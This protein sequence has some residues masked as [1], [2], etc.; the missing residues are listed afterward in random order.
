KDLLTGS[1]VL[2]DTDAAGDRADGGA[3]EPRLS[4]D[5]RYVAFVSGAS[6]LVPGANGGVFV[7]D[8]QTGAITCASTSDAGVEGGGFSEA[9]V[10][11]ADGRYVAFQSDSGNL[12]PGDTNG[13]TDVFVKDLQTGAIT[14]IVP[15]P[16][17][18]AEG[19]GLPA[20]TADGQSVA[21]ASSAT[22]LIPGD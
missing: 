19:S 18:Q 11:S 22:H 2:A 8:L 6:N 1:I 13:T 21:F 9:P 10:L 17:S 20:L 12:V 15:S 7:K 4:A 14:R 16:A 5:G 3:I